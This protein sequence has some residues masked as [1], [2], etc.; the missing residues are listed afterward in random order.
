M[1]LLRR[2]IGGFRGLFRKTQIEHELDAELREFLESSIEQKMRVGMSRA[3][4][5]RAARME[6]GSAE[7]VKDRVRDVGWESVLESVWRDVR[8]AIRSL[9]KSPGFT[10]VAVLSLAL[11]IGANAA[12]FTLINAVMLR[13]LPVKEPRR[14]VQIN[15]ILSSGPDQGRPGSVPYPLFA[16]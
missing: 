1:A 4:A 3:E 2:A 14:M 7:A 8:Y 15:R 12:I 11:G 9:R 10:S 16:L 5:V 13:T 6:L